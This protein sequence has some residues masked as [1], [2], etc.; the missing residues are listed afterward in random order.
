MALRS[1]DEDATLAF[2]FVAHTDRTMLTG[3]C[4]QHALRLVLGLASSAWGRLD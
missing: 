2:L 3:K 1:S 4:A